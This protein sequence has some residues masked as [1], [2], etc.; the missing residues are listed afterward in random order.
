M[1]LNSRKRLVGLSLYEIIQTQ[2]ILNAVFV[3]FKSIMTSHLPQVILL[4]TKIIVKS[5][6]VQW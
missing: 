4:T 3:F 6:K 5:L 2:Q 1:N